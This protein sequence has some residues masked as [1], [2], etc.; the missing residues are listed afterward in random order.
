MFIDELVQKVMYENWDFLQGNE[1]LSCLNSIRHV[2]IDLLDY[3]SAKCYEDPDVL[4]LQADLLQPLITGLALADYKP[5]FWDVIKEPIL[6]NEISKIDH[7]KLCHF[8]L[9]LACLE[10]FE[11]MLLQEIFSIKHFIS[12]EHKQILLRLY[13]IVKILCPWYKGI[14]P[15]KDLLDSFKNLQQ[16]K[17][18]NYPLLTALEQAVGGNAY[19]KTNV[20]T[21]LEHYIGKFFS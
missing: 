13:Q 9:H 8:V 6:N 3:L 15:L 14:W 7:L 20:R 4:N 10:C 21:R 18:Q 1:I 19:I 16:N 11:P 17:T 5:V 2:Q 12:E